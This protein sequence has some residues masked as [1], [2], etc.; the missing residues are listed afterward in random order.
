MNIFTANLDPFSNLSYAHTLRQVMKGVNNYQRMREGMLTT[1]EFKWHY[2]EYGNVSRPTDTEICK[3]HPF[4]IKDNYP[5][6]YQQLID[7]NKI[8]IVFM[9]DDVQRSGWLRNVNYAT[10]VYWCPWD[11]EDP[12]VKEGLRGVLDEVDIL[13]MVSKFAQKQAASMGYK[14]LQVYNP[15]DTEVFKP[16]PQKSIDFKKAIGIPEDDIII[17]WVGRPGWRKRPAHIIK[18][19]GE[20]VKNNPKVHFY[21]HTDLNDHTWGLNPYEILYMEGLLDG[22]KLIKPNMNY[23]VGLPTENMV[24]IYNATDVYFAPHGGE[25]QGIPI[26]EAMACGKPFVATNYTTTQEFAD[27]EDD[28]DLYGKRGIGAKIG[29]LNGKDF[30]FDDKGIKRPYV[31]LKDMVDKIQYLIDNPNDAKKMG[32]EGRKFV[33]EEIDVK[34]VSKKISNLFNSLTDVNWAVSK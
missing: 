12:R 30:Y 7:E 33:Q 28:S 32:Q 11:N 19:A 16:D 17:T 34:V 3:I 27:Y 20:I 6:N 9:H 1:N 4:P 8:D 24:D 5:L 25:G 29:Q 22:K 26:N 23:N 14:S 2:G 21:F 15:V 31:D 10:T 13:M 18:V